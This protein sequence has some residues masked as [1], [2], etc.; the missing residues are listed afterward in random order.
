MWFASVRTPC[1]ALILVAFS[2]FSPTGLPLLSRT[3]Q[4]YP[5]SKFEPVADTGRAVALV[6]VCRV[7][8]SRGMCD[9]SS[10]PERGPDSRAGLVRVT[11]KLG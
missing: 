11:P 1:G 10:S 8:R 2:H 6:T 9:E 4:G 3:T 5:P 7:T